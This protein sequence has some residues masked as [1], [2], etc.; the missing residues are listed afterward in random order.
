MSNAIRISP[1]N[2]SC[3]WFQLLLCPHAQLPPRSHLITGLAMSRQI[4]QHLALPHLPC[5]PLRPHPAEMTRTLG[6]PQSLQPSS[7]QCAVTEKPAGQPVPQAG[8]GRAAAAAAAVLSALG[9]TGPAK[10]LPLHP[11]RR[12][13]RPGPGPGPSPPHTRGGEGLAAVPLDDPEDALPL[14][15]H[16]L[17]PPPPLPHHPVPEAVPAPHPHAG[18]VTGG[19]GTALTV[20]MTI[21]KGRECCR[22]SV[23]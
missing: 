13:P 6:L 20:H 7:G 16:H 9:P 2:L 17:P 23:Q 11:H 15:P 10:H 19:G 4:P 22:R 21:T 14:P 1:S 8:A 5:C 18:E 3:P 12:L